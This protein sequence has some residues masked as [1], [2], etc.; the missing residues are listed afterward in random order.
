[1][2]IHSL[3]FA[4]TSCRYMSSSRLSQVNMARFLVIIL[5]AAENMHSGAASVACTGRWHVQPLPCDHHQGPACG[6][7]QGYPF[8]SDWYALVGASCSRSCPSWRISLYMEESP[9]RRLLGNF[10]RESFFWREEFVLL[11]LVNLYQHAQTKISV[12]F[13]YFRLTSNASNFI[14]DQRDKLH[15]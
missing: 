13:R 15:V 7:L 10:V 6:W 8:V 5:P 4:Q 2:A 3:T 1:M 12:S 9:R 14:Q 11:I